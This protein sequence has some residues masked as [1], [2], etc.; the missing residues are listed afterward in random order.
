VEFFACW[1]GVHI[2][3]GVIG[4]GL[5]TEELGAV[6]HIGNGNVGTNALVF[7]GNQ[8]FFRTIL[9]V[10]GD[11]SRPQF[12]A[13]TGTPEQVEHGLIVHDFRWRHQRCDND[14]SPTSIHHIMGMVAQVNASFAVHDRRIG[15]SGAHLISAIR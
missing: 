1:T 15:I 9:L 3:L 6:I 12:P 8:I 11:V 10:P 7:D 2:T 14:A 13:K 4:E 5:T